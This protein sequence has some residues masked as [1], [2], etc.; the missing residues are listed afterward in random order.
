MRR[1]ATR[2][3]TIEAELERAIQRRYT[4]HGQSRRDNEHKIDALRTELSGARAWREQIANSD[5][6][7]EE[8]GE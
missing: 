8:A 7:T 2:I 6:R 1:I 5:A 4:L 3:V